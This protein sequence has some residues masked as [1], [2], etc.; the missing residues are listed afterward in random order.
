MPREF[1]KIQRREKQ[2]K[3]GERAGVFS[4]RVISR[5]GRGAR[6]LLGRGGLF[7]AGLALL[8][9]SG[10]YLINPY[11]DALAEMPFLMAKL[12]LIGVLLVLVIT[13]GVIISR[14]RKQANPAMLA[15]LKPLG[16]VNFLVGIAIVVCAV[17]AFH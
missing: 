1:V 14:A 16:M 2:V 5:R 6:C 3:G 15:K 12:V 10:I 13:M 17:M 11:W 8:V 7:R 4:R 9:V